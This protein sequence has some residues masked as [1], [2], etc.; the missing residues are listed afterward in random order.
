MLVRFD[1][2]CYFCFFCFI[3]L[4]S[5]W[6]FR[7][8]FGI[9]YLVELFIFILRRYNRYTIT[10]FICHNSL[11][12]YMRKLSAY[13]ETLWISSFSR[14][15]PC[16]TSSIFGSYYMLHLQPQEVIIIYTCNHSHF[17]SKQRHY[18]LALTYRMTKDRACK[19]PFESFLYGTIPNP[20]SP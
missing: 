8:L 18:P 2:D 19:N 12:Q 14:K 9:W 3:W 5:F 15:F 6:P 17:H 1:E 20:L 16:W 7:L 13:E 11:L 10:H 4:I